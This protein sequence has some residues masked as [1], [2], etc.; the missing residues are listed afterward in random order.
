MTIEEMSTDKIHQQNTRKAHLKSLPIGLII[1][2][3]VG[4]VCC[5]IGLVGVRS[6]QL[7]IS[8]VFCGGQAWPPPG[9]LLIL[10][11]DT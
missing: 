10:D 7:Y 1:L 3:S 4:Q 11:S 9:I 8:T 5:F 6:T 2:S